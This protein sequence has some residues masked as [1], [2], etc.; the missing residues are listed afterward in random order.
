MGS[1][2]ILICVSIFTFFAL[3][4]GTG[5]GTQFL[6]TVAGSQLDLVSI[7]TVNEVSGWQGDVECVG[8]GELYHI[9]CS[10]MYDQNHQSSRRRACEAAVRLALNGSTAHKCL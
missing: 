7:R 10:R 2:Q 6:T 4:A 3:P 1:L 9:S 5:L 8:G